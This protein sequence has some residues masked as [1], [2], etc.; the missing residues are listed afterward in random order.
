SPEFQAAQTGRSLINTIPDPDAFI[1]SDDMDD[2]EPEQATA[3]NAGQATA[4]N[5]HQVLSPLIPADTD[6]VSSELE[7]INWISNYGSNG[8]TVHLGE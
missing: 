8:G 6:I 1:P 2:D 4:A 7:L 5:A 3:S